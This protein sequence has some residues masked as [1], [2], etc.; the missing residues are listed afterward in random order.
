[1]GSTTT[2]QGNVIM[3]SAAVLILLLLFGSEILAAEQKPGPAKS[4]S[5]SLS[6]K[7]EKGSYALDLALAG[8]TL[9]AGSNSLDITVRDKSGRAVEGARL[10]VTPWLQ[11]KNHG[12]W[13]KPVVTE[14]GGGSYHVENVAIALAGRWNLRVSVKKDALEDRAVFSFTVARAEELAP[15]KAE[16]P[17]GNYKRTL[18]H[19][20]VPN[21]TLL[22]QD[23]KK[24]SLKTL[25]DSGKPVLMDFIYTTCNTICPVL[26]ASF[27]NVRK[28][29]GP[30]VDKVQFI[31]ISIDPEHDRPEQ[32]KK[33]LS[34]FNTGK[35]WEFLT[36]SR[37]D[38][39][40]VLQA[41]DATVVDKMAHEPL[42]LLHGSSS[43]QWVRVNGLMR[44]SDLIYE[45]R[46]VE[47]K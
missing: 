28:G 35:G 30:E 32:M 3:K 9:K 18:H 4:A 24:V 15:A 2:L 11:E 44:K 6:K 22:N 29:L 43:D 12:V 27:M 39:A 33:Y 36:G 23:G 25:V 46:S 34:R 13:E 20:T 21:V 38:I 17:R 14:R 26:S 37:E 8:S 19:Y 10:S 41:L 42:Y 31:S 16:A 40:R 45:L 47:N 7:T 5:E 1:M